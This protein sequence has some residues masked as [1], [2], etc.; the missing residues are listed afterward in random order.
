MAIHRNNGFPLQRFSLSHNFF[1]FFYQTNI[2]YSSRASIVAGLAGA[3]ASNPIDV[4]KV[5]KF[6]SRV[7]PSVIRQQKSPA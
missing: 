5:W 2:P 6:Q 1:D 3:V 7:T 4:V